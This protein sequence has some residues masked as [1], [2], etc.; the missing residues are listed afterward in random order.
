MFDFKKERFR[1][2]TFERSSF[3]VR[4]IDK[5]GTWLEFVVSIIDQYKKRLDR[6]GHGFRHRFL[7]A[8]EYI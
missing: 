4:K 3:Q 6:A 2:G 5:E 7:H 1:L 8:A